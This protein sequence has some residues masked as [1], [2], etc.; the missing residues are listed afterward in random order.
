MPLTRKPLNVRSYGEALV[1]GGTTIMPLEI[2]TRS[3]EAFAEY[4]A[5]RQLA[6][7]PPGMRRGPKYMEF[8]PRRRG[9]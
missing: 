7:P 4:H 8:G 3:A 1:L 6:G 2:D 5:Y 9:S